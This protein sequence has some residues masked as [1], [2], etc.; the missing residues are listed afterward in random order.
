VLGLIAGVLLAVAIVIPWMTD[1]RILLLLLAA[2]CGV[3]GG[4][5]GAMRLLDKRRPDLARRLPAW[6]GGVIAVVI[7]MALAALM[8]GHTTNSQSRLEQVRCKSNLQQVGQGLLM[9]ANDHNGNYPPGFAPLIDYGWDPG[10]FVCPA[11]ND[12]SARA[13]TTQEALAEF[14]KPAHCSYVYLAGN[15]STSMPADFVLAYEPLE[16][17]GG[18]GAHFLTRDGE[19]KWCDAQEAAGIIRQLKAGVNPPK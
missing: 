17:H 10:I 18:R 3:A 12:S 9:Y 16:I 14:A 15:S 7:V 11:S 5:A 8:I 6:V 2:A 13:A 1:K 4:T 19:V